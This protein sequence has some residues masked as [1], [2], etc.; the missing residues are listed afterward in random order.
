MVTSWKLG[1]STCQNSFQ[2]LSS[3]LARESG[4]NDMV[5]AVAACLE[6]VRAGLALVAKRVVLAS[7]FGAS[8]RMLLTLG[9]L[10]AAS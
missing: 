2:T 6:A 8:L 1:S 4:G 5:A 3:P 9:E 7:G 10:Y